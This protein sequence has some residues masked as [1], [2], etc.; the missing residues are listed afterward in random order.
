MF[1]E[2][3]LQIF[4]LRLDYETT[5]QVMSFFSALLVQCTLSGCKPW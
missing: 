5:E 3:Q 2:K 1:R 4:V